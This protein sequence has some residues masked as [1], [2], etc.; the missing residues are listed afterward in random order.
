LFICIKVT[1]EKSIM[2]ENMTRRALLQYSTAFTSISLLP[3]AVTALAETPHFTLEP[4]SIP[5][6]RAEDELGAVLSNDAPV[7]ADQITAKEMLDKVEV[8]PPQAIAWTELVT[9]ATEHKP[10]GLNIPSDS[11]HYDFYLCEIPLTTIVPEGQRL[12]RLRLTLA[13]SA[14]RTSAKDLVAYDIFP[15]TQVDVETIMSGSANV[16]VSKAL[17]FVTGMMGSSGQVSPLTE[18]LGLKL[19]MPFKWTSSNVIVQSSGRM[20][21]PVSWY[22][23]DSAIQNGFSPAVIVRVPK[24]TKFSITAS[25]AGDLRE[26]RLLPVPRWWK[27]FFILS[28]PMIYTIG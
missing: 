27:S 12:V 20:S 22:V 25:L 10:G 24:N 17:E 11:R 19:S 18:A 4:T 3:A 6:W 28:E 5:E 13:F 23:K 16:D 21:N 8:R 7:T 9:Y 2:F 1:E 14:Q 15:T 26:W